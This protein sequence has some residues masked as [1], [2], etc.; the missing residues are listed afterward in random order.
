MKRV[1]VL[2]IGWDGAEPALVEPWVKQGLLP[3]L[4]ELA[5]RGTAGRIRST[6]PPVTPP[7]WTSAVTGVD[8]GRH[9]IYSFTRP[10]LADYGEQLVSAAER[11]APSI[12]HYL[13]AGKRTVGVFNLSLSY[14]PE[15]VNGFLFAGFDAPVFTAQI[16]Y[17]HEAFRIATRNISGYVHEGLGEV[18]GE[19]AVEAIN[20]Q[21][22]QQRD[23]LFN[24]TKEIPVEVLAVNYN[25]PD[26]V[27]HHAWPLN[28]TAEQVAADTEGPVALVYRHLDGILGDLLERFSDED[29]HVVLFSDHGGGGMRGHLSLAQALEEGGFLVRRGEARLSVVARL[30]RLARR[31]LPRTL[32]SR[33]WALAGSRRREQMAHSLRAALVA[34]VDWSRTRAFPW[35]SSG[36]VQV[37]LQGR[38]PQGCVPPAERD[39]VLEEVEAFLREIRDPRTGR[40]VVGGLYRGE[41]LFRPPRVGYPPDLL[42]EGVDHEYAVMPQWEGWGPEAPHGLRLVGANERYLR[43]ITANHRP[44]GILVTAGPAVTP[45]APVPPLSM[46]DIAPTVLYLAG[47]AIPEGLDGRLARCLWDTGVEPKGEIAEVVSMPG[48]NA[49]P[50]TAAEQAAVEER[51]RDLGYM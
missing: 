6:T 14:P 23:M 17:P 1:R 40:P 48:P 35:G 9:G 18:Q 43:G 3:T 20:R 26:H 34:N 29:T 24:L 11:Q 2:L 30:R 4:G 37:N 28:S 45:G 13:S 50:Y 22:R 15:P 47:Q 12:W 7:A 8:P 19:A 46:V 51:L 25:A 42:A 27:H 10:S 21:I 5:R 41:D 31:A 33:L 16:V 38:E 39:R 36:F 44:W 49:A 32:K